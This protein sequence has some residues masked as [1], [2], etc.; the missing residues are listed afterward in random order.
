MTA[1]A[2]CRTPPTFQ[3]E[4]E[5]MGKKSSLDEYL[6]IMK[7]AVICDLCDR[8][9]R[10]HEGHVLD[11]AKGG[12]KMGEMAICPYCSPVTL[13]NAEKHGEMRFVVKCPDGMTFANWV[14]QLRNG[15]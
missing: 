7:E 11:D 10:D 5:P 8:A 4:G 1:E 14:L 13:A 3:E 6:E 15:R 2:F 9:F 12:I